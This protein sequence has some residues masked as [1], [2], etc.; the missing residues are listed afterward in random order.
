MYKDYFGL[1]DTPFSIAPN[2]EYLYMSDQHREA[3]GHLLYGIRG[4]GGFLLL[5]GEVGTGKTTVCRC[6]LQQVPEDVDTAFI[7]NPKLTAD[8]MLATICDEL[9]INY[10]DDA[11]IKVLVDRLNQFL[12]ES[13][14]ADRRT[15]V[16][17]DEAQNLS[18]DVLEQLRLLTNLETNE[19]KLLQIVLLGQPELLTVLAKPELRQL[20]QRVTAR[21]HLNALELNEVIEYIAHRL[22]IAG[23]RGS[24]F[25]PKVI[26]RIYKITGGI[27]RLINLVCDRALLGTYVQNRLEVNIATVNKAAKETLGPPPADVSQWKSISIAAS[28]I[29]M[30]GMGMYFSQIKTPNALPPNST[31][32][33]SNP[34]IASATSETAAPITTNPKIEAF[35]IASQL[36]AENAIEVQPAEAVEFNKQGN[37]NIGFVRQQM[38]VKPIQSMT[39]LSGFT[40]ESAAFTNLYLMWG[41]EVVL[42]DANQAC[43]VS[44]DFGMAC[45]SNPGNLDD[46][47][48]LNRPVF[49]NFEIL[50]KPQHLLLTTIDSTTVTLAGADTE[51]YVGREDFLR[52]W[53]GQYK[54]LWRLPPG[55][56]RP[57]VIGDRGETVAWLS[58]QLAFIELQPKEKTTTLFDEDLQERVKRFQASV[59][60]LPDGRV[61]PQT[62]IH[63]NSIQAQ[64]V[65]LLSDPVYIGGPG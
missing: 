38:Q 7:L 53:D 58:D 10:P 16:I 51:F 4:D 37:N 45:Y 56:E 21:F 27:P 5:T 60:L 47:A 52:Y 55:Y 6:L 59:G 19:R 29:V 13:Y 63:I 46:I 48:N 61:G 64:G 42:N 20:S 33:A 34:F 23:A 31:Q 62:W 50:G 43:S 8:E 9:H 30:V 15:V 11:S 22:E 2:P 1:K 24:L 12:L 3:L 32:T 36:S 57:T 65:P 41:T 54:L 35:K 14:Q 28:L 17:I 26:K 40:D 18:V 49:V 44:E 39:E 25:S